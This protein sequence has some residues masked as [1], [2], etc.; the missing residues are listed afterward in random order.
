LLD[1]VEDANGTRTADMVLAVLRRVF[2]WHASRSN[3]FSS[4]IVKGMARA[5]SKARSR[6]LSD[7]ELRAVWKAAETAGTFGAL[8][9]FLLLTGARRSEAAA[10]PWS[11]LSGNQWTLPPARNKAMA[12]SKA[13]V[14]LVRPLSGA[15]MAVLA[16]LPRIEG[17][18]FAFSTDGKRPLSGFSKFK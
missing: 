18:P 17:C 13:P 8:G 14:D 5:E 6:V 3:T 16:G 2:N 10:L 15:A 11:E 4:P 12:R 7:D 1:R 9:R